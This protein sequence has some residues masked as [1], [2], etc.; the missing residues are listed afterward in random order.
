MVK[1]EREGKVVGW[2]GR[3]KIVEGFEVYCGEVVD[4][5]G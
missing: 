4:D 1:G 3:Y 2:G 5:E